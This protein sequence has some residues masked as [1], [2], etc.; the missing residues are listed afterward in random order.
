MRGGPLSHARVVEL[1]NAHF[2]PVYTANEDYRDG[3]AAPADERAALTRIQQEGYRKKLSVG[4]VH[5]YVLSPDGELVDS[6]H[7][8]QAAKPLELIAML[9]AAVERFGT[10][11]GQPVVAPK[12]QSRPPSCGSD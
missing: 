11:A 6:R 1:L 12:P 4:T 5:V 2:V 9:Q 7:V 8:A 10:P 3:G